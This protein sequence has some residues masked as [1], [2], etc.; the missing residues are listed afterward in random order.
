MMKKRERSEP[1]LLKS[2][3]K[4]ILHDAED[5]CGNTFF[6]ITKAWNESVD[7]KVRRHTTLLKMS[8]ETLFV[9]VDTAMWL[10]EIERK[11]KKRCN[12]R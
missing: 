3:I 7:E 5:K 1:Q 8:N 4:E 11:Y 6:K 10:Y 2:T 9:G 12:A